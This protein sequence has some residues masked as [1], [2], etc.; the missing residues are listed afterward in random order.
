[1]SLSLILNPLVIQDKY[2]SFINMYFLW[3]VDILVLIFYFLL[4]KLDNPSFHHLFRIGEL[5]GFGGGRAGQD[6]SLLAS[7]YTQ[8]YTMCSLG[9]GSN[10]CMLLNCVRESVH[11]QQQGRKVQVQTK[12]F[13]HLQTDCD[14]SYSTA[15][16]KQNL[17]LDF[18]CLD[19]KPP[20]GVTVQRG[21]GQLT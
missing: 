12:T 10:A 5:G 2:V 15:W 11:P 4:G 18:Q 21:A 1:M 9:L 19:L 8:T 6:A 17:A 7:L 16:L 14:F 3:H 20:L 13:S